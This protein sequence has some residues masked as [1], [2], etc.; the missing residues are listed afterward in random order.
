MQRNKMSFI[1]V[2]VGLIFLFWIHAAQAG[3][4]TYTISPKDTKLEPKRW[5]WSVGLDGKGNKLVTDETARVRIQNGSIYL[6]QT[7]KRKIQKANGEIIE[8]GGRSMN[9]IVLP[10]EWSP[11]GSNGPELKTSIS[12]LHDGSILAISEARKVYVH[13]DGKIDIKGEMAAELMGK[14][15]CQMSN[16]GKVIK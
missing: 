3:A 1:L 8:L 13:K 7:M 11:N 9:T 14:A 6:E 15:N 5:E 16:V 12:T 10:G 4:Y 2:R